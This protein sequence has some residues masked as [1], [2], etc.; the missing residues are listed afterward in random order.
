MRPAVRKQS[1]DSVTVF[2]L[3]R[4]AAVEAVREAARR[5]GERDP[6]VVR[7]VLFGSLADGTATAASDADIIIE[8]SDSDLRLL[9]RPP[10]YLDAF[11]DLGLPVDLFVYTT[12]EVRAAD[13]PPVAQHALGAGQALFERGPAQG[14]S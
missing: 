8:L 7:V 9:D 4:E 6:S 5:V 14:E 2:W 10:R 1:F 11:A 13:P 12:A 3:D